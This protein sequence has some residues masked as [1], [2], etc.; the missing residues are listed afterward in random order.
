MRYRGPGD[1][2]S[3]FVRPLRPL[4]VVPELA[5]PVSWRQAEKK[6][7]ISSQDTAM[8]HVESCHD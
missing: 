4:P 5:E 8:T 1:I 6:P 7:A 2:G 3:D